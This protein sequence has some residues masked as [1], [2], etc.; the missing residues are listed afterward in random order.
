MVGFYQELPHH[1]PTSHALVV[2]GGYGYPHLH[3][4]HQS[5]LLWSCVWSVFSFS[6]L[7][8]LVMSVDLLWS[9]PR[10]GSGLAWVARLVL[11]ALGC[12]WQ[13]HPHLH[14]LMWFCPWLYH[15]HFLHWEETVLE[16]V[17]LETASTEIVLEKVLLET[18]I[19][20][21]LERISTLE[22]LRTSAD[23]SSWWSVENFGRTENFGRIVS[24]SKLWDFQPF[25]S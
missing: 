8:A 12:K 4:L 3:S 7:H 23:W 18:L 21:S 10:R 9:H 16:M 13:C 25:L 17:S 14:H 11:V 20:L 1:C 19:Q 15:I 6:F 2:E 24:P 22:V 5:C